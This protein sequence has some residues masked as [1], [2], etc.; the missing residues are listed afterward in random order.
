MPS[1]IRNE[2]LDARGAAGDPNRAALDISCALG[3]SG[4][5]LRSF[6]IHWAWDAFSSSPVYIPW[7]WCE[8]HHDGQ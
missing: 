6:G 7:T 5:P 2:A 8:R 1:V 4:A 3:H